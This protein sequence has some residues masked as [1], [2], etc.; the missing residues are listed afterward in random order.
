MADDWEQGEKV[1]RT[2]EF[3]G[4]LDR[5]VNRLRRKFNEMAKGIVPRH[6]PLCGYYG[7]FGPFGSPPRYDA[8]CPNC[9]ALER[10][11]LIA[12]Y[13]RRNEVLTKDHRLLH[14]A[15][16][17]PLRKFVGRKVGAYETA[18]LR[19]DTNPDHVVNIEAID[20]PDASFDRVM[21]NHVLEHV[22]DAKALAEL[23]RVLRP[24]GIAFLT[25]PVC[26]GWAQTYENPEITSREG[27]FLHFGQ[28]DHAR[29]YGRDIRDRIRAAGFRLEELVA[30][31]PDVHRYGL[32]RG[33]TLFVAH[34]P[35][36]LA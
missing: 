3:R 21:C 29:F 31:E 6:C 14:F 5:S 12:L 11:R 23:F 1:D 33:E 17:G 9:A 30:V 8:R 4:A 19:A 13:L 26:E 2:E 34:K 36:D 24:G 20:L 22:D 10:H 25:T 27:R 28:N 15:A 16:E 35:G 7:N 18:E 32:M